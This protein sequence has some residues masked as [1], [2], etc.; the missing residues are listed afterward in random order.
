MRATKALDDALVAQGDIL[1][2]PALVRQMEKVQSD[3]LFDPD[4]LTW[5]EVLVANLCRN[6]H[7][8]CTHSWQLDGSSVAAHKHPLAILTPTDVGADDS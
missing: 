1:A 3:A 5:L 4:C 8:L 2:M 6:S 7:Q